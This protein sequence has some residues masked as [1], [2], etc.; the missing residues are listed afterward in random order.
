MDSDS[1]PNRMD[2]R[3]F[4]GAAAAGT[5]VTLVGVAQA[6]AGLRPSRPG[7]RS[8]AVLG[9]GVAGLSAAHELVERGFTVTVYEPKALGGKARSIPVPN[10]A[11]GGRRDLP[12]EHGFRFF[13]GFYQNLPDTMAR[14]PFAG[15]AGGV[16]D[17]LVDATEES[18]ARSGGRYDLHVPVRPGPVTPA[19][20]FQTVMAAFQ[21]VT[22]LPADQ[23]IFFGRQLL[24]YLTSSE[25]RRFGQWEFTDWWEFTQAEQMSQEYRTVLASGLTRNLVAARADLASTRTIG[26]MAEA[27]VFN[28][29]GIGYRESPDRVLSGPTNEV[30]IDPWVAYLT[31]RGVQFRAAGVEALELSGGKITSARARAADGSTENVTAD[32][33]LCAMPAERAVPLWNSA[34]LDADPA[35][36]A[37]SRLQT[38]WMNGIQFYLREPVPVTRGHVSYIDSPWALTSISQAQFWP[39][40]FASSYGDGEVADCLSV[41]VSEWARPGILYGKAAR[42]CTP[43]EIAD[44]VWA[45]IKATLNDTGATVLRDSVQHSWFLDP[46]ITYPG[47]AGASAA[48]DEPLLVNTV[49]SWQD[50]PT[51]TTAIPNL[52]LA[53]DYVQTNIDLATMEGA[54]ESARAAVNAIVASSGSN[55]SPAQMFKLY[56]PPELEGF[57]ALDAQSFALGQP[58]LFDTPWPHEAAQSIED[59][60]AFV[61]QL[62]GPVLQGVLPPLGGLPVIN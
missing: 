29:A 37:M 32:W 19:N 26:R 4:L 41:D 51:A 43:T 56:A 53:S 46:A 42:D 16:F 15:N 39:G 28:I 50:R 52:F 40:P 36:A 34:I 9:G 27:F 11:T 31:G 24:V 7:G 55:A 33:Y 2:R 10:T 38:E 23:L 20:L 25:A 17:N 57:K 1:K 30:W 5:A 60:Y 3:T 8:V 48:N 12:G 13:P 58:N 6:R 18:F 61:N 59:A 44:E 14:I 54:N 45:Q 49:G 21:E 62:A 22:T 47:G 35:L